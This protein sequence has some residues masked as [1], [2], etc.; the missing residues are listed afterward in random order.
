M[1][2]AVSGSEQT[3]DTHSCSTVV[4]LY[5]KNMSVERDETM[6]RECEERSW[7]T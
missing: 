7:R 1:G 3:V 4:S 5:L 6:M 2:A